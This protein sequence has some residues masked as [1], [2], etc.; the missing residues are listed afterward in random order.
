MVAQTASAGPEARLTASSLLPARLSP[1][2][3][4]AEPPG[5]VV[6]LR[7]FGVG[8]LILG[9]LALGFAIFGSPWSGVA[10]IPRDVWLTFAGGYGVSGALLAARIRRSWYHP[11]AVAWLLLLS[12]AGLWPFS[13]PLLFSINRQHVVAWYRLS[14]ELHETFR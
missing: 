2:V 5:A 8:C 7:R 13:V 4:R 1:V 3:F 9:A 6:W 12:V 11:V 14:D 10:G